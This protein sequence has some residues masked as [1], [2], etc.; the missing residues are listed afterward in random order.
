M[1]GH[2][3]PSHRYYESRMLRR[4]QMRNDAD[5]RGWSA[6]ISQY[7]RESHAVK[8]RPY[9]SIFLLAVF[10]SSAMFAPFFYHA[11]RSLSLFLTQEW[12]CLHGPSLSRIH[13]STLSATDQL[14]N[15]GS[16]DFIS[17][18]ISRLPSFRRAARKRKKAN[19]KQ[20]IQEQMAGRF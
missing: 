3:S 14:E 1:G 5:A 12:R 6:A 15:W 20:L 4:M 8:L 11:T 18:L 16:D 13:R 17:T 19:E 7:T 9:S 2:K 10:P